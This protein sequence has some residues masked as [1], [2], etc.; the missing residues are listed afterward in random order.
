MIAI[1]QTEAYNAHINTQIQTR[2][3]TRARAYIHAIV[4]SSSML[5]LM[6]K[7]IY[8]EILNG[9]K[10]RHNHKILNKITK[11]KIEKSNKMQTQ[12]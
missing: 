9:K 10:L 2:T 11:K 3:H 7:S 6:N 5:R 12:E 4:H 1:K 8:I